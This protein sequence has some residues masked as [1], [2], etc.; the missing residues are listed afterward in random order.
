MAPRIL[1]VDDDPDMRRV[2]RGVLEPFGEVAEA[3]DG[4]QALRLLRSSR[5]RPRLMLLDVV[6][7]ELNGIEVLQAVRELSP[8]LPVLMLTGE[9]DVTTAKLALELGAKAYITKPFDV[10]RLAD[11]AQRLLAPAVKSASGRPW[12]VRR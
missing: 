5:P 1:I 11:E 6:M 7:P 10:E 8:E 4:A 3:G 2:L 9:A 12:R